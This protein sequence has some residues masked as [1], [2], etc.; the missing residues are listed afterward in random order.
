[1]LASIIAP[2]PSKNDIKP[3]EEPKKRKKVGLFLRFESENDE[4]ISLSKRVTSIFDGTI[5]LYYYYIDSGRYELQPRDC[6]VEV[7]D[8]ELKEL[9]RILG[10][11][12]V[13]YL[14]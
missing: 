4:R 9:K 11:E 8:T 14:R 1:M 12:N 13:A 2:P 10:E 6:F 7:N 3:E 5:P